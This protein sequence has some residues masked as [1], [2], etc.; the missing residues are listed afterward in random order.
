MARVVRARIAESAPIGAINITPLIDVMLVLL[1]VIILAIP[2]ATHKLPI[3]LPPPNPS[4]AEQL[5]PSVLAIDRQGALY[6]NGSAIADA[7]LPQKLSA[8][9]Q[10]G[11]VLHVQTDPEA[12]YE[13]FDGVLA[14]VKRA[15][16]T[17]LG[18]VGNKP[19]D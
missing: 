13:R 16:I 11:A 17:K 12:R 3:E 6:W 5:P 15:G 1:V 18:F 7:V 10:S 19:L 14:V 9:Q 2:I 4:A 8:L